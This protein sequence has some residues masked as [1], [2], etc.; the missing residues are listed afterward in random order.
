MTPQKLN[1]T[2]KKAALALASVFGIRMLGLFL[3]MPVLAVYAQEYPDYSPLWVG[4]ALGAYGLTQ[5]LLQIPLGMLSDRLGRKPV[6][7][8]GLLVFVAGS[9]VAAQADTL[10]GVSVGR[11]LQGLGAIAAAILAL[12]AD[13]SRDEQRPKVMATIGMCIGLAFAV[14]LV[15]GPLLGDVIGL[16]GLFWFTAASGVLGIFVLL[17]SVP[18]VVTTSARRE[19]L[20]VLSELGDLLKHKQLWCLNSGIF[21]LHAIL[22]AWFVT[23][24][25]Q[26]QNAGFESQT[27][28]WFYLPT[29]A[30]S[31][32]FMVPMII[33]SS[34]NNNSVQW[35]RFSIVTLIVSLLIIGVAGQS[36]WLL[37]AAL[38]IF[39]TG[40]NFIEASL[41]SLLTRIAPAGSKGSAS[42]IYSTGQFLGAFVGGVAGGWVL[43]NYQISGVVV[44]CL[45]LLVCWLLISLVMVNPAGVTSVSLS[46]PGLSEDKATKLSERLLTVA[47]VTEA[48]WVEED[49]ATYLKVDKKHYDEKAVN[50]LLEKASVAQ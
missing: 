13:L 3:I 36:G 35:L 15:A 47:G 19:S 43:Q 32:L 22:T 12:A 6:I 38:V 41:P 40:F 45:I 11:A 42:G 49:Q 31:I 10:F 8:G 48:R 25:T 7:V 1:K 14:S 50:Q 23:L 5:A 39:F 30:A 34:R 26:L 4:I 27:H 21:V 18:K 24:P 16:S 2:E 17:L 28:A 9:V 37:V 44:F 46:L 20:P 29:L 33:H